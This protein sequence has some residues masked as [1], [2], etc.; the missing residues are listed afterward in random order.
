MLEVMVT[1]GRWSKIVAEDFLKQNPGLRILQKTLTISVLGL[2]LT[3]VGC[4]ICGKNVREE[5]E[6]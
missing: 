1:C 4:T 5:T 6:S 3:L 2:L